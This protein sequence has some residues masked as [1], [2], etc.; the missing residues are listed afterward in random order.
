MTAL[1]PCRDMSLIYSMLGRSELRKRE[2][3][4]VKIYLIF[5][6]H[7]HYLGFIIIIILHFDMIFITE[8]KSAGLLWSRGVV[9]DRLRPPS[10][11]ARRIVGTSQTLVPLLR[12][13]PPRL[14]GP[15]P[16][17]PCRPYVQARLLPRRCW[18]PPPLQLLPPRRMLLTSRRCRVHL[19]RDPPLQWTRWI[20][21]PTP[22]RGPFTA[23]P[24]R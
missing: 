20:P 11:D 13:L 12:F 6:N 2:N 8:N 7:K 18:P 24:P 9:Q 5:L 10:T 22:E 21:S 1:H 23:G 3:K 16:P 4:M 19:V 15:P 17:P 14:G